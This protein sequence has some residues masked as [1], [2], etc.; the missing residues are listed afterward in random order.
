MS[1]PKD[2]LYKLR[3]REFRLACKR[4]QPVQLERGLPYV[5]NPNGV[6]PA[7]KIVPIEHKNTYTG[8]KGK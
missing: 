7:F 3:Q 1:T 2:A 6:E 8:G 4:G 5:L